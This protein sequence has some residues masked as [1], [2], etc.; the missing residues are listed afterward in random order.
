MI[1]YGAVCW[2]H[3]VLKYM[4]KRRRVAGVDRLAMK[5]STGAYRFTAIA[6]QEI[7]LGILPMEEYVKEKVLQTRNR[8][9]ETGR[10]R[11]EPYLEK[12][13]PRRMTHTWW[14]DD[15]AKNLGMIHARMD[16]IVEPT[17]MERRFTVEI[18]EQKELDIQ[19]T[20]PSRQVLQVFSDG[21]KVEDQTGAA[22][23]I[24]SQ[25]K[26]LRSKELIT[27]DKYASVFQ[28]EAI[29]ISNAADRLLGRRTRGKEIRFFS[30][31][32]AAIKSLNQTF[33]KTRIV[34]EGK[35]RLNELARTN[36]VK[37]LWCPGHWG[38][39]VNEIAD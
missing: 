33:L 36:A 34:E 15:L 39:R 6:A 1:T 24:T 12:E 38:Y 35:R 2:A 25:D 5:I 7:I 21:S 23:I 8:L 11:G 29:A 31:S 28:A 19:V 37:L 22:Y 14:A 26:N 27:L 32:Q 16:D 3:N 4:T 13:K 18:A 20:D 17:L 10:W 30:D 9:V